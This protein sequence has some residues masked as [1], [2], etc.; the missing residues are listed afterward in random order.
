MEEVRKNYAELIQAF[1]Q[2]WDT[3][4]GASRLLDRNNL[5]IAVNRFAA[6][7]G[8][9]AGQICAKMGT[10]EAHRGCLKHIALATRTAQIDR[11]STNKIRGWL[12]VENYPD[13]VVHFSLEVPSLTSNS[14]QPEK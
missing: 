6:E 1:H 5:T 8:M 2:T 13:I 4:P 7:H 9:E 14:I 11:P 3:F 12:P 10:P